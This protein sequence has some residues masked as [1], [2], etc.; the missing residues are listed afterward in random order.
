MNKNQISWSFILGNAFIMALVYDCS[1]SD[2][3]GVRVNFYVGREDSDCLV[4]FDRMSLL[5]Y[6]LSDCDEIYGLVEEYVSNVDNRK[7]AEKASLK[8]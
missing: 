8:L 6:S 7:I 4:C 1:N 3:V 2:N 5:G